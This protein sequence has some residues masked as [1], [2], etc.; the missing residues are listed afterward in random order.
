[1]VRGASVW[2]CAVHGG[3]FGVVIYRDL[4]RWRLDRDGEVCW[5]WSGWEG[6]G[7]RYGRGLW[8]WRSL[9]PPSSAALLCLLVVRRRGLVSC[10]GRCRVGDTVFCC[11]GDKLCVC[12]VEEEVVSSP[13]S[14]HP[15][16]CHRWVYLAAYG[17]VQYLY[18]LPPCGRSWNSQRNGC[19]G[20]GWM[21]YLTRVQDTPH[22]LGG[23]RKSLIAPSPSK[24]Q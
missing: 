9:F 1:M 6:R 15:T 13:P 7:L 16:R 8:L 23:S 12:S 2:W 3:W 17:T 22:T 21:G 24:V 20:I 5:E 18:L 11:R 19:D 4:R 10:C 14:I